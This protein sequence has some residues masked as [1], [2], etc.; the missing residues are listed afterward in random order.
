[1]A[2]P[3]SFSKVAAVQL[4]P[5]PRKVGHQTKHKPIIKIQEDHLRDFARCGG[6]ITYAQ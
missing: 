1:M 2:T 3:V 5:G 4:K 6:H